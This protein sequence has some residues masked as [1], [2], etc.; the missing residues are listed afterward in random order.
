MK[1]KASIDRSG[2]V[3][4]TN[5]IVADNLFKRMKGL[6][7]RKKLENGESLLLRPCNSIHT[8]GMSFPIDAIFLDKNNFVIALGKHFKK[9]RLSRIYFNAMSVLEL[10]EGTIEEADVRV[11]DRVV[12]G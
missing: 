10:P 4:S 1:M 11:G 7:G 9:N 5:V 6:L 3:L 8:I 2:R 12:I